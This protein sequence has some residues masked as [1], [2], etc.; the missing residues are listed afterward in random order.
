MA[1]LQAVSA[2][3]NTELAEPL[4]LLPGSEADAAI[5]PIQQPNHVATIGTL[6]AKFPLIVTL[7]SWSPQS[8][9]N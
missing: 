6:M 8:P 9:L 4:Q 1:E 3:F 5:S 2:H 7:S